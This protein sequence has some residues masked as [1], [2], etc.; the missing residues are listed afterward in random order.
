MKHELNPL[1][2]PNESLQ[3]PADVPLGLDVL[4]RFA[5]SRLRRSLA[6]SAVPELFR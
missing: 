4:R 1:Q 2:R 5:G 6:S 3:A